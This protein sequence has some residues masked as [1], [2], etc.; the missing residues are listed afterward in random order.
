VAPIEAGEIVLLR[1]RRSRLDA[2]TGLVQYR[3]SVSAMP[4]PPP[5][6]GP[7]ELDAYFVPDGD[8]FIATEHTR[9][10]WSKGH[11]HGG[12]PAALLARAF[13][14][15]V[16]P[17]GMAV[18]RTT[19]ELLS[20]VPIAA[21]EVTASISRAGRK[22]QRLD[23]TLA[24]G[25]RVVCRAT[26]L[27]TRVTDLTLASP[28]RSLELAGPTDSAPFVFPFFRGGLEYAAA[29]ETRLA[30]GVWGEG[31]AALWIRTRIPLLP[32]E[33]PSPLQRTLIAAD[34]G[35]GVAIVLDRGSWTFVNADLTVA[36]HRMPAGEWVCVD[37]HTTAEPS[38]IGLTQT[39]LL[40][41]H[42]PIGVALQSLVIEPRER[43]AAP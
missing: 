25:G 22:V 9:G 30:R 14:H 11:Q 39:R 31:S 43:R 42:G 17:A 32:G 5:P 34:S 15:L 7:A 2:A 26:A 35:N 33:A 27:A 24:S 3:P 20:P 12:P 13:E 16:A 6:A 36:L 37:A 41:E 29:V 8:R 4:S 18:V 21:L 19:V 10:P 28:V 38:G 1:G 23:G 40:D